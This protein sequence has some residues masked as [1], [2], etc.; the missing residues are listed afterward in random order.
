M[1]ECDR[2]DPDN[3]FKRFKV[4]EF[5]ISFVGLST[6]QYLDVEVDLSKS[7]YLK[8]M[9]EGNLLVIYLIIYCFS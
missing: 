1:Y 8:T 2:Y 6:T 4:V 7:A 9:C 5:P 3:V